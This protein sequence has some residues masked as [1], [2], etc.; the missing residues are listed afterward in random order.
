MTKYY[1]FLLCTC[2]QQQLFCQEHRM[3]TDRPDQTESPALVKKGWLQTESGLQAEWD[4]ST[5]SFY[6]PGTLWK[7][8]L[9]HWL[10]LRL[11]TDFLSRQSRPLPT[12]RIRETGLLP[13]EIGCKIAL[14]AEK[15]YRPKTSLILQTAPATWG[16]KK[17]HTHSWARG[18]RFTMQH[19]LAPGIGLGY[20]LG[21]EWDGFSR[22]PAFIY[23]LSPGFDLGQCWYVYAEIYGAVTK[24]EGPAHH[25]ATGAAFYITDDLKLDLSASRGLTKA[26][27]DGYLAFGLSF[28]LPVIK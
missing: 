4:E 16:N 9:S 3:E 27:T 22:Q 14:V 19:T 13:L 1:F 5:S 11:T 26:A 18:F 6:H 28:R 2:L 15:I 23:T 25:I 24:T 7:F 8:G 12:N 17:F 21:A 20:N 10:E